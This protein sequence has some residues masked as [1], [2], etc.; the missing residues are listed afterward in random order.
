MN[1]RYQTMKSV[2][3]K[4]LSKKLRRENNWARKMKGKQFNNQ[5]RVR[6]S[7]TII[8]ESVTVTVTVAVQQSFDKKLDLFFRGLST[9]NAN[10]SKH[11]WFCF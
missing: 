11:K 7:C 1:K 6:Y 9:V 3:V 8:L 5:I 2:L 4:P 10:R